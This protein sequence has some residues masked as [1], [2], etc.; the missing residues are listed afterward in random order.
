MGVLV[1]RGGVVLLGDEVAEDTVG[2][3]LVPVGACTGNVDRDRVLLA[4]VLGEPLTRLA[5]EDD[6][7]HHP[8]EADEEVV[9][10]ALVVMEAANHAGTRLRKVHLP[11]RL[12]KVA[13]TDQ[14]GEPATLVLVPRE[15]KPCDDHRTASAITC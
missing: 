9:L 3:C 15:W 1:G 2:E 11:D 12:R 7:A 5:V 8:G 14:L 4:D 6:D 13:R 10:A